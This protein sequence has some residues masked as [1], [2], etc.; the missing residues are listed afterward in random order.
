M[1]SP[2]IIFLIACY[3]L[4]RIL[5][6]QRRAPNKEIMVINSSDVVIAVMGVTGCGK[7]SFIKKVTGSSDVKVGGSLTSGKIDDLSSVSSN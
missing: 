6:E 7:S 3:L 5:F 2:T 1:L 4:H